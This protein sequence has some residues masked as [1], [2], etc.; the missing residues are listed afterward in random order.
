M[1][2]YSLS[3]GENAT[4][5]DLQSIDVRKAAWEGIWSTTRRSFENSELYM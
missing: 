1:S 2:V 3:N 4:L 5:V